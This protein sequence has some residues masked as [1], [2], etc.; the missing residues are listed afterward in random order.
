MASEAL[1]FLLRDGPLWCC[2]S[3]TEGPQLARLSTCA[4]Q[5]VLCPGT[6]L[7]SEAM[8]TED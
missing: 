6:Y 8:R 5:C 7:W 4:Q 1:D 3:V 2:H